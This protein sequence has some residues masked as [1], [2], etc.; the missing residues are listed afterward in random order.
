[1]KDTG[2]G[3][4]GRSVKSRFTEELLRAMART[5]ALKHTIFTLEII[6]MSET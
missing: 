2:H 1:M 3:A 4:E 5:G 6:A